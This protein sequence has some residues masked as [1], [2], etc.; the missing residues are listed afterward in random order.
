MS[1]TDVHRPWMLQVA[2]PYNR[3]L[4]YYYAKWPGRAVEVEATSW[5]NLFCGCRMCTGHHERRAA[6][7][8]ERVEWRRW[9]AQLLAA[10]DRDTLDVPGSLRPRW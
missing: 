9:R 8:S 3:H 5:R 7:R 4:I 1:R 2:D 10:Q 6:H